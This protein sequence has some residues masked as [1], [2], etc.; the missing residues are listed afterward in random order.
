MRAAEPE[1]AL[2]LAA[3]AASAG[4]AL[5]PA[6]IV[7]ALIMRREPGRARRMAVTGTAALGLVMGAVILVGLRFALAFVGLD[8]RAA[9]DDVVVLAFGFLLAAPLEQGA[10]AAGVLPAL[11]SNHNDSERSALRFVLATTVG[12]LVA[13]AT[14]IG[15]TRTIDVLLI[16][17]IWTM[18]IGQAALACLWGYVL[19][20]T[21]RRALGGPGFGPAWV[22]AVVFGASLDHLLFLRGEGA[23]VA[24]LPLATFTASLALYLGRGMTRRA[25]D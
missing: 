22:A 10:L 7:L 12:F 9:P 16:A 15:A 6:A 4:A 1:G 18:I 24:A 3:A 21:R 20:V 17:R 5:V 2:S 25:S 13:K 14:V 11:R 23:L 8:A 19:A